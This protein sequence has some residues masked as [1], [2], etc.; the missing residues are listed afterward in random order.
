MASEVRSQVAGNNVTIDVKEVTPPQP[1]RLVTPGKRK[2]S[3][4]SHGEGPQKKA[5]VDSKTPKQHQDG[6]AAVVPE[7]V[8]VTLTSYFQPLA[9]FSRSSHTSRSGPGQ[10]D[11]QCMVLDRVMS[12]SSLAVSTRPASPAGGW[13]GEHQARLRGLGLLQLVG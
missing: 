10:L 8:I 12:F 2:A 7:E 6:A 5:F 4:N 13:R 11:A 3:G 1:T 9:A